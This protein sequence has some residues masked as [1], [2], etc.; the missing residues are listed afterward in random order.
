MTVWPTADLAPITGPPQR[1]D[2]DGARLDTLDE[3]PEVA[4]ALALHVRAV[5][6]VTAG[7]ERPMGFCATSV[8]PVSVRP[9]VLSFSSRR[10][11][12]SW[13][14]ISTSE[15]VLVHLLAD[16]QQAVAAR[17]ASRT[18]DK[19]GDGLRWRRGPFGLPQIDGALAVLLL[20][21]QHRFEVGGHAIVVGRVVSAATHPGRRPLLHSEGVFWSFQV[22]GR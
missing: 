17:F 12:R 22:D 7:R 10:S 8:S 6:V 13:M 21:I 18:A 19:F 14:A 1:P 2:H 15:H 9:P 11:S 5:A 16:G 3:V 4:G 20:S